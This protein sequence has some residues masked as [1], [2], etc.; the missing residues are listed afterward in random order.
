MCNRY[1]PPV[2]KVIEAHWCLP[3]STLPAWGASV[4]PRAPGPFIRARGDGRELVVGQWALV[5]HFAKSAKLTYQTNNARSEELAQKA[6]YREP[7]Q[8]GQRCIIPATSFDEPN[9]TCSS[10]NPTVKS[11]FQIERYEGPG[12]EPTP[13]SG[14]PT[15]FVVP[16]RVRDLPQCT[17]WCA[18]F[19]S[20]KCRLST[21]KEALNTKK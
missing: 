3:A 17:R 1:T 21:H 13:D 19:V 8:R 4:Y 9:L 11:I 6:S 12:A 16:V 7:W 10:S 20:R 14:Y 18:H 15:L 2:Q 5:P